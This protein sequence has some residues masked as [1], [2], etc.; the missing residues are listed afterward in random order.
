MRSWR[1]IDDSSNL[2]HP[3][4][5]SPPSTV[6][7]RRFWVVAAVAV[8]V[9]TAGAVIRNQVKV[10]QSRQARAALMQER[11]PVVALP[12]DLTE[13]RQALFDMLQPVALTDCQVERFGEPNDGGYLMCGNLLSSVQS[14]TR[15]SK[16]AIFTSTTRAAS[17]TSRRSRAGPTKYSSSASVWR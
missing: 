4:F 2:S 17:E 14:G 10:S 6:T 3:C 1:S 13:R 12:R 8:L 5:P 16:S 15:S 7:M 11:H 9:A